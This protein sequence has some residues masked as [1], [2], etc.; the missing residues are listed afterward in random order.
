MRMQELDCTFPSETEKGA[1]RGTLT[2]ITELW[3]WKGSQKSSASTV[4]YLT[5]EEMKVQKGY[6]TCPRSHS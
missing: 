6:V 1:K 2:L 4:P 5:I 3:N